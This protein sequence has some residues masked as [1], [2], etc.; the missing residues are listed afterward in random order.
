MAKKTQLSP[1]GTPGKRRTF[2]AKTIA[3]IVELGTVDL[4]IESLTPE[5]LIGSLTPARTLESATIV[6]TIEQV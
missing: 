6:R 5:R 4:T 3:E 2:S 1:G